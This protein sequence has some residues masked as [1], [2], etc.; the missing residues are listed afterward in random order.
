MG[1]CLPKPV[2][3]RRG[4]LVGSCQSV[5]SEVAACAIIHL[6]AK[7]TVRVDSKGKV[8]IRVFR[9]KFG[10]GTKQRERKLTCL[11]PVLNQRRHLVGTQTRCG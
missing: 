9:F 7:E 11:G 1:A 3:N 5:A 6:D 2:P 8:R 10:M 4:Q